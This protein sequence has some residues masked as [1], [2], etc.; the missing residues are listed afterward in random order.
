MKAYKLII[1]NISVLLLW[2]STATVG[3]PDLLEVKNKFVIGCWA[4]EVSSVDSQS[5]L[6]WINYFRKLNGLDSCSMTSNNNFLAL[7]ACFISFKNKRLTHEVSLKAKCFSAIRSMAC[8]KSCLGYTRTGKN[9]ISPTLV[10]FTDDGTTNKRVGHRRWLLYPELESIG[11]A[12]LNG[13]EA[14]F[15]GRKDS[16]MR[17]HMEIQYCFPSVGEFWA[18]LVPSRWSW[19]I[20]SLSRIEF[21]SIR[22][23]VIVNGR[24]YYPKVICKDFFLK[25][26][27]VVW[28]MNKILEKENIKNSVLPLDVSV[29]IDGISKDGESMNVNYVVKLLPG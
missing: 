9:F 23:Q 7:E 21:K 25:E 17:G 5:G 3:Q 15:I 26:F 14:V 22:V 1:F 6:D 24:T 28:D 29:D 18:S 13:Y 16:T 8:K 10:M 27:T 20:Y 2:M 11:Y 19:S 4:P 12:H